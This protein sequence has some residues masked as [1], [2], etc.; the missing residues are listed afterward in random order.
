MKSKKKSLLGYCNTQVGNA[1]ELLC[2]WQQKWREGNGYEESLNIN[3]ELD[4]V[5]EG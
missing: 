3:K 4:I 2:R 1:E 5:V